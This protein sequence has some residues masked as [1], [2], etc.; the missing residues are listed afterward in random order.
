MDINDLAAARENR[1][2]ILSRPIIR[3]AESLFPSESAVRPG[4]DIVNFRRGFPT[5]HTAYAVQSRRIAGRNILRRKHGI[6][7]QR[8]HESQKQYLFHGKPSL[9]FLNG[10][11]LHSNDFSSRQ[12][13]DVDAAR[14]AEQNQSPPWAG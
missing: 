2:N 12:S 11:I 3:Q 14:I 1:I 10:G 4:A 13:R 7:A 9:F 6:G 5:L 8:K